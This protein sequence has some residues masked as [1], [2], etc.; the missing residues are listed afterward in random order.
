LKE[1][2]EK[3]KQGLLELQAKVETEIS[4]AQKLLLDKDAELHAAEESLF[5]LEQVQMEYWVFGEESSSF[6]RKVADSKLEEKPTLFGEFGQVAV[7]NK[8]VDI[9]VKTGILVVY[10]IHIGTV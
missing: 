4:K 8:K 5:G 3:N 6:L 1:Q 7:D 10:S 2:I 9:G